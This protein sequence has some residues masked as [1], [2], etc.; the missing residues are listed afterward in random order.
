[1]KGKFKKALAAIAAIALLLPLF[2]AFEA[3]VVNVKAHIENA[4]EVTPKHMDFGVVFPQEELMEQ[5]DVRLS[6]S[7]CEQD[8]VYDVFYKL[9]QKR[10]LKAIPK[11]DVVF[12]FDLTGSM[13][14]ALD[15]AQAKSKAIMDL[16]SAVSPDV[17]FGVMSHVDYPDYYD[18]YGYAAQYG[19]PDAG[20]YAYK[21]DQSLTA[22]KD[23]VKAVIDG[24]VT[25]NGGDGPQNYTRIMYESYTDG[26]VGWRAGTEQVVIMLHDNVPHD[27]NINEGVPGKVGTLSRG[28]DPGPN[29]VM[30][31]DGDDLDLQAELANMV[32]NGKKLY[33]L[34][35]G[36][37]LDYWQH[38]TSLTGGDAVN[39]GD[40]ADIVEAVEALFLYEDLSPYLTKVKKTIDEGEPPTSEPEPEDLEEAAKLDK[41]IGDLEDRWK[42]LFAVPCIE[43]AV[44]QDYTGPVAP[45]DDEDYGTDI[46][47]E[48]TGFSYAP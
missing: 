46:W 4:L 7:F 24:L 16:L 11:L 15:D 20:D 13:V 1:M 3:H 33:A 23:A 36:G 22:D 44:G 38:W 19:D 39:P 48:V 47:V 41:R 45:R 12:A 40:Y 37:A 10:K 27:D 21:L 42:V 18:S 2:A 31:F 29:E 32:T 43:G 9:V 34:H 17:Q 8:R 26:A 5:F 14:F 25:Y 28:G 35:Y 30:D 6:K